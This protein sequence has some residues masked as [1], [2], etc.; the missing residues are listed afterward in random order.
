MASIRSVSAAIW[1]RCARLCTGSGKSDARRFRHPPIDQMHLD[2]LP[3]AEVVDHRLVGDVE[4]RARCGQLV[5]PFA[6]AEGDG[7]HVR[8]VLRQFE[9]QVLFALAHALG[10]LDEAHSGS[11]KY[12]AWIATAERS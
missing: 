1:G 7:P 10:R 5:G 11:T 3:A 4:G 2:R 9:R 6:I 8:P 12:R